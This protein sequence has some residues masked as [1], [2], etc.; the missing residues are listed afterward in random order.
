MSL[1]QRERDFLSIVAHELRG[2]ITVVVGLIDTLT[3]RSGERTEAEVDDC[4]VRVRRQAD[5]LYR[6][7][8]DL[9]DLSQIEA[10]KFR[11]APRPV[12]LAE[13][14]KRALDY[15]PP[16]P[17]KAVEVSVP[18]D[19][20]VVA[21]PGRLDQVF[22]NLLTNAY[23]YGGP[24]IRIEGSKN[25]DGVL[26]AVSDDGEGVPPEAVPN[27]FEHFVRGANATHAYGS[28]L[29]LAITRRVVEALGGRIWHDADRAKGACFVFL[30]PPAEQGVHDGADRQPDREPRVATI[31]VVDDESD[32]RFL[33][34][35][36]LEEA[37]HEVVEAG[38]GAL[39]L[40]RVRKSSPDLVVTDL[41]MPVMPGR[42]LIQHLRSDPE[43]AAIP[44]LVLSAYRADPLKVDALLD[45]PFRPHEVL[46]TIDSL[47]GRVG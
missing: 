3:Q 10:G 13:A 23:R 46:A 40:E 12:H 9:L 25:A 36:I 11:I 22:V 4:L 38:H 1:R 14:V 18:E 28:G 6:L 20:W 30:L 29:G 7:I 33:L 42:E 37:G 41:M 35:M 43:T 5:R 8:G 32:M 34:R 45:K 2:P 15:A 16:P 17:P 27:L 31:L 44:I 26:T 19:A 21:D 39:A 24:S 47:L